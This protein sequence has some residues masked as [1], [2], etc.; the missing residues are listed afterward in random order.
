[1]VDS[2]AIIPAAGVSRRMGRPKLLMPWGEGCVIDQVLQAWCGSQVSKVTMTVRADDEPLLQRAAQHDIDVVAVDPPPVDMKAS[3]QRALEHIQGAY[4][5]EVT[6]VWLLAPA[7]M[8]GL[9]SQL[10]DHVLHSHQEAEPSIIA[11]QVDAR[12]G[13]PVLFPWSLAAAVDQLASDVGIRELWNLHD[14]RT[15]CWQDDRP[16][17]D[18]DTWDD[19]QRL[20]SQQEDLNP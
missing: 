11:P 14:G 6:A 17:E 16:L 5:P 10:I 8:P 20:Q 7:D 1:M 2:Y 9:S 3:V 18:M 4:Q 19:Y 13:H 12:K 15:I